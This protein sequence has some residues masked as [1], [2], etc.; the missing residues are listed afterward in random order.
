ME[1]RKQKVKRNYSSLERNDTGDLK[2]ELA[3]QQEDKK[4]SEEKLV[5]EES[6]PS[7]VDG[8]TTKKK[9]KIFQEHKVEDLQNLANIFRI[10]CIEMTEQTKS[11]HPTTCSS[12][13]EMM[14]ILFFDPSGLHYDPQDPKN[15]ANDKLILSKGHAAPILCKSKK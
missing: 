14:A 4:V 11:G 7:K 3:N 10:H 2:I 9:S 5:V 13:A 1:L 8:R 6:G 12:M 15:L